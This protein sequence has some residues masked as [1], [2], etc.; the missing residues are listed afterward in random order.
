L[1][2]SHCRAGDHLHVLQGKKPAITVITEDLRLERKGWEEGEQRRASQQFYPLS[3]IVL[4]AALRVSPRKR[5]D[6]DH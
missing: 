6:W 3:A 1:L 2:R 5:L 4:V